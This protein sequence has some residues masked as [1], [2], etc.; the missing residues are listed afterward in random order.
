MQIWKILAF[1]GAVLFLSDT[2]YAQQWT[3]DSHSEY[4]R[5]TLPFSQRFIHRLGVEGR[6]GYIFQTNPFL[7]YSNHQYKAMKNAYAGH[8]KYSFQLRPHTVADQAYIGAYQGIG[9]GYFNFGNPEE[10]GNPLAVYLFQGGRIA[11]FSPRISLNYEWNFGASFG[12][13]P[14][15]EYDNPENQIIGS[16]VNAY[17]N[18]NLYLKWALSPKFDLMIGATGSHF[19]NG[20]TQYPNSGLNTVDCKVGLVYNFNRRADELAQSWQR[21][22]VPPFPRHVSYDLTLFGSWRKKAVPHEGS[23]GQVPAPGTYNVFGFSFA[24]M[25]NFGYK[26]RAGVA[27]DG[28]YLWVGN[29]AKGLKRIDLRTYAVKHYDNIA[30]DIFS[31]CRITAGDLY[32]GTTIGLFRYNPDTERF[33]RVPELGWTFVYYIKED[34]QGNLWLATYADGVYKKNVRTGGWEHFVHEEADSS[35]LPSNKVLSIFEDSQN[36]L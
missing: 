24:P 9:V 12:W 19:S 17:L 33:K 36:Q 26:F 2:I 15:D 32:L 28:D 30:S 31:I 20:N 23:S 6:A 4:K 22:I 35:T 18:V 34:K 3:S 14:Y 25:Y 1:L 13:K 29:F 7:E 21:P 10:L 11:Q 5:D 27:L 16:K 8:L